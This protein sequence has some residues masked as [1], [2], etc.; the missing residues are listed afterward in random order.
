MA[1][2]NRLT[3]EFSG[4]CPQILRP[5]QYRVHQFIDFIVQEH[6]NISLHLTLL[7]E[8]SFFI[9]DGAVMKV[10]AGMRQLVVMIFTVCIILSR[11]IIFIQETG[12]NIIHLVHIGDGLLKQLLSTPTLVKQC[13]FTDFII[14]HLRLDLIITQRVLMK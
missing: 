5:A 7:S 4:L 9:G 11:M 1:T 2:F 13:Q 14:L 6:K 8:I 3:I 12:V 10:L